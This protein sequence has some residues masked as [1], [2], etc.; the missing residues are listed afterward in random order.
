MCI[1]V[2]CVSTVQ[3]GEASGRGLIENILSSTSCVQLTNMII[4]TWL[5]YFSVPCS[6]LHTESEWQKAHLLFTPQLNG[7]SLPLSIKYCGVLDDE[8]TMGSKIDAFLALVELTVW[9]FRFVVVALITAL[10]YPLKIELEL[11][12]NLVCII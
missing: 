2:Q 9:G 4:K 11:I 1:K 5:S 10:F 8:I 12:S 7:H 3:T 6:V